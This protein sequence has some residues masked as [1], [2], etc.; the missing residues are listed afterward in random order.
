MAETVGVSDQVLVKADD[1]SGSQISRRMNMRKVTTALTASAL[2]IG[3]S[4]AWTAAAIALTSTPSPT[5]NYSPIGRDT[6]N[7]IR[8]SE[9][10]FIPVSF[11]VG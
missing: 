2:L 1:P 7:K 9:P 6:T 10:S 8:V 4:L 5:V 11:N 3:G